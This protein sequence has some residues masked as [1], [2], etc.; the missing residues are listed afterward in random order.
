MKPNQHLWNAQ[1]VYIV[2]KYS[3]VDYDVP[4]GLALEA[5][6]Q[7]LSPL[8]GGAKGFRKKLI[9]QLLKSFSAAQ[10][11]GAPPPVNI[12]ADPVKG[13]L[14]DGS[15]ASVPPRAHGVPGASYSRFT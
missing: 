10:T 14:Q 13:N 1:S 5:C 8:V 12:R 4:K 6:Q 9:K 7:E 15:T 3:S 2:L 11:S